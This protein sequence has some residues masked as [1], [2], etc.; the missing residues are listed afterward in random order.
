M[1]E[2]Y[3][4]KF[5]FTCTSDIYHRLREDGKSVCGSIDVTSIKYRDPLYNWLRSITVR[6]HAPSYRRPCKRC[7]PERKDDD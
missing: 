4:D 2:T 3:K 7:F 1:T 6:N 5:C